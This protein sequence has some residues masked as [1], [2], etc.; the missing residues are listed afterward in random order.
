MVTDTEH[1]WQDFSQRLR[2]FI[3]RRVQSEHDAED[4][5][6][7]TFGKV[8]SGIGSL[9]NQDRLEPWLYQITRNTITDYYRRQSRA[10]LDLA[11]VPEPEADEEA[12][13]E[14]LEELAA[15]LR[16]M[17]DDL[18]EKYRRAIIATEY[19]G[20]S[21]KEL[22]EQLGMSL[23]GA[24][25]RVQRAKERLKGTMLACCHF[26]FDRLS[27]VIDYQPKDQ[28]CRYCPSEEPRP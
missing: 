13:E 19:E 14:Q 28:G 7:D 6:Q 15:C 27:K 12:T 16:P 9:K 10:P 5:L 2:S 21:Q 25:S 11:D 3:L 4:I 17:I 1:I 24:K 22:S 26:E 8:H 20:A 18:P 23:S